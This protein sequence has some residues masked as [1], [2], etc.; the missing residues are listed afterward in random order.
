M[1]GKCFYF[2]NF[3]FLFD[4][5]SGSIRPINL[6]SGYLQMF[7]VVFITVNIEGLWNVFSGE[8]HIDCPGQLCTG[9]YCTW[10]TGDNKY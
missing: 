6:I 8:N 10:F 1:V 9:L 3:L 5:D 4:T 2:D 7:M